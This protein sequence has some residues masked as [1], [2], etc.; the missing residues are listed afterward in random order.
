MSCSEPRRSRF[1]I[2][3]AFVVALQTA[4][5]VWASG[6]LRHRVV[7]QIAE[8]NLIPKAKA[9]IAELLKPGETLA[10]AS[11]WADEHRSQLP[12]TAP[13]H[14]VDVPLYE[15]NYD[16]Q[17]SADAPKKGCVVD[18]INEFRKTLKDESKSVEDRRFALRFQIHCIEDMHMPMHVGDNQDRDGN[19]TQ[20]RF[21]DREKPTA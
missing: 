11:T 15:P 5:P 20:V 9:A 4:T 19:D 18:K 14:Y 17:W 3:L 13:W 16:A 10:D 12:K 21:F 7:S 2:V 8:K 6:R 1:F